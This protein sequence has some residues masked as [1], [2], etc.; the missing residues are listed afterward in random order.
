MIATDKGIPQLSSAIFVFIHSDREKDCTPN[1]TSYPNTDIEI[2]DSLLG[3]II[4]QIHAVACEAEILYSLSYDHSTDR[5]HSNVELFWID[6]IDGSIFLTKRLDAY[7]GERIELVIKAETT[8]TSNSVTFGVL[9]VNERNGNSGRDAITIHVQV[10][11]FDYL[12]LYRNSFCL[13]DSPM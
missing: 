1:F 11:I 7:I 4:T 6:S 10:L 12:F 3:Q 2:D 5:T 9:V 13:F 8:S